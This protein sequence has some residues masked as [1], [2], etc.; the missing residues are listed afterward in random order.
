MDP[1]LDSTDAVEDGPELA[2]PHGNGHGYL[3]VRGLLPPE[4]LA[5][6]RRRFLELARDGGWLQSGGAAGGGGSRLETASASNR[7]RAT[8]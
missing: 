3:F 8:T 6:L 2:P 4:P 7:S 1:Y 5:D